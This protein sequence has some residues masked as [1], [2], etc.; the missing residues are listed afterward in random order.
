MAKGFKKILSLH[1]SNSP[2]TPSSFTVRR[3]PRPLP[4]PTAP[5]SKH[6]VSSIFSSVGCG[7]GTQYTSEDNLTESPEFKWDKTPH[8]ESYKRIIRCGGAV[9]AD[10]LS[11]LEVY[12]VLNPQPTD[13]KIEDTWRL[14][15]EWWGLKG[16]E[17]ASRQSMKTGFGES[18]RNEGTGFSGKLEGFLER[19]NWKDEMIS[20]IKILNPFGIVLSLFFV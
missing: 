19:Q 10:M 17:V 3:Q 12:C 13:E 9:D 16:G 20:E 5:P 2:Q 6:H 7:F 11:F 14:K 18:W 15:E 4:N 8:R 1:S